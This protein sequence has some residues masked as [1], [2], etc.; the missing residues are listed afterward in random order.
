M[1]IHTEGLAA[2]EDRIS[3]GHHGCDSVPTTARLWVGFQFKFLGER[4]DWPAWAR[5]S[6]LMISSGWEDRM[7]DSPREVMLA[8]GS[9]TGNEELRVPAAFSAWN[10]HVLRAAR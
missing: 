1:G 4:V 2:R 7:I 5:C 10:L 6:S 3:R 9:W 8:S